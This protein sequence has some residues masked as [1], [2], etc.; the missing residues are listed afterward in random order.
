M[1]HRGSRVLALAA[2]ALLGAGGPPCALAAH[3]SA[4]AYRLALLK[5]K[6]HLGV[7]R[8][9]LRQD[10]PGAREHL[11]GP[12]GEIF[13]AAAGELE[14]RHAALGPDI[15]EQL[16]RAAGSGS[17]LA[18]EN[19]M[20]TALT[21]VDGSLARAGPLP[22]AAALELAGALFR[23]ALEEYRRGVSS[24]TVVSPL[25]YRSGAGYVAVG[26]ALT[27]RARSAASADAYERLRD[28]VALLREAWP[29][30]VA[31]QIANDPDTVAQWLSKV[32]SAIAALR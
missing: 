22:V 15:V 3:D 11:H 19:A 4:H 23:E 6:A 12:V 8:A 20:D 24:N 1:T 27:R 9:L 17:G 30:V 26:A 31:P 25:R 7:A 21:A 29:A 18:V 2:A 10:A 16:E 5:M 13:S 14:R 32:E 28:A